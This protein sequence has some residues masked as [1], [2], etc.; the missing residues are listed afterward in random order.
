MST[1]RA[2]V[3]SLRARAYTI[4]TDLPEADGT[5][6]W[7]S[8]TLVVVHVTAGGETGVGYT[9]EH[10]AVAGIAN[11]KL[12]DLVCGRDALDVSAAWET[13]GEQVRNIGR[14]GV[15]SAAISAVDNALW[16]LK[17]K[18]LGLPLV[19][20]LGQAQPTIM[21]YGSGGFT[22]YDDGQ[23]E[24]QLSD[25]AEA[26]MTMVKMKIGAEPGRDI[27]R[28]RLAR[29][30]IGPDVQL[31]VDANG[32]Y[33]RKEALAFGEAF[34]RQ[35]VTWFEEPVTS[36]DRDGLRLLRDRLPAGMDVAAGEYGWDLQHFHDLLTAGAVDCLQIDATRCLGVTGFIQAATLARAHHL[37]VSA[38]CAPTLHV[39]I[40]CAVPNARHIE[41]FHDHARI[42]HLLFDGFRDAE[43]GRMSPSLDR[44]GFGIALKEKDAE[45]FAV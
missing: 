12:A 3:Q 14:S 28:V 4:P 29:E 13:M 36:Q 7:T 1:E 31:G 2:I 18:L 24:K 39:P 20:L 22:S 11:T 30:A 8:T 43:R 15:A 44:P 33:S 25:W 16:D 38:H 41:Y 34:G 6:A 10:P 32:A 17:A 21:A 27:T 45:E 40:C 37:E 9:Y 5:L 26:G 19:K 23:L 35:G 42:E